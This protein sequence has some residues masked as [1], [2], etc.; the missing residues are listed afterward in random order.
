MG[1]CLVAHRSGD[2]SLCSEHFGYRDTV[3]HL[4]QELV[5]IDQAKPIPV[6]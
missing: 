6:L 3:P 1:V 2:S 4:L 5:M